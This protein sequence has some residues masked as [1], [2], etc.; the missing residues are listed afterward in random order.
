L[1]ALIN[2]VM[3]GLLVWQAVNTFQ[4]SPAVHD[5]YVRGEAFR[6]ELSRLYRDKMFSLA[7]LVATGSSSWES[8]Y[9]ELDREL[10]VIIDSALKG[11]P[12]GFDLSALARLQEAHETLRERAARA[13][14][15]S[16]AG[17]VKEGLG[18]LSHRKF[19]RAGQMFMQEMNG[20]IRDYGEYLR[21]RLRMERH[22]RFVALLLAFTI[23]AISVAVW[24]ILLRR[25][26]R[27]DR[28]RELAM[29]GRLSAEAEARD[30]A[31]RFH[32][33]GEH[34]C[35]VIAREVHDEMG[36]SLTALK[37]DLVRLRKLS[38][39][40]A[41]NVQE[42]LDNLFQET[43]E[44]IGNVQR[45]LSDLR[46]AILEHLG[47][48]ET[49][50]WKATELE[51]RTGI[52]CLV[53]LGSDDP[54]LSREEK[55]ALFRIVQ[56]SLTNVAR[57]SGAS[58]ARIELSSAGDWDELT[59]RDNGTGMSEV[60]L[61]DPRSYGLQGMRERARFFGGQLDIVSA[62]GKGTA[63]RVRI[64]VRRQSRPQLPETPAC[65]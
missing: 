46:P 15:L 7:M 25:M 34:Q 56:E 49:I 22:G 60:D 41:A 40:S 28:E 12:T 52:R 51:E 35:N 36:Q 63:V 29:K 61:E 10:Y 62:P 37:I 59:I 48:A 39:G 16:R 65:A 64:P 11:K 14:E 47:L 18:M 57:H 17:L 9:D 6:D 27:Y 43:N 19:Q 21:D 42:I 44:A 23:F 4:V 33:M 26:S 30:L 31:H 8:R 1:A 53:S 5:A 54:D 32:A 45:L 38:S 50:K 20:F 55:I 2:L 13:I 3:L 58:E 24:V